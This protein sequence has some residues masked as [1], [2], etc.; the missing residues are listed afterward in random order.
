MEPRRS[1]AGPFF[2][3]FMDCAESR[4][5]WGDPVFSSDAFGRLEFESDDTDDRRLFEAW[6]GG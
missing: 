2:E 5:V 4:K 6:G 3:V 1:F